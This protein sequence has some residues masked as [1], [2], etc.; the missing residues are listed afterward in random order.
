MSFSPQQQLELLRRGLFSSDRLTAFEKPFIFTYPAAASSVSN[1]RRRKVV[2]GTYEFDFK[3]GNVLMANGTPEKMSS[4]LDALNLTKI[5]SVIVYFSPGNA[6]ILFEEL[7]QPQVFADQCSGFHYFNDISITKFKI[8][9]TKGIQIPDELD[10]QVLGS[11]TPYFPY[12][13][14]PQ[15]QPHFHTRVSK[16]ASTDDYVTYVLQHTISFSSQAFS[17]INTGSANGLTV[18]LQTVQEP[19]S[20][21]DSDTRWLSET[22]FPQNIAAGNS[23]IANI[24]TVRHF[25]RMRVK[26]QVAGASSGFLIEFVGKA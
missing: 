12:F 23:V 4:S 18:D 20:P 19:S 13:A 21:F 15:G 10:L 6:G 26:S 5:R 16:S 9:F 14:F 1:L 3:T 24:N 22:G 8:D 17:I 11:N 2:S 7:Q 25:E